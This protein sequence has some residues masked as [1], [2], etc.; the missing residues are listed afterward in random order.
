[1]TLRAATHLMFAGDASAA[2]DL[3]AAVF[4][5]FRVQQMERYGP[6]EPGAEG[7]VKRAD[8]AFAGHALIVIDSPVRHDFTF[9]PAISLFVDCE[10]QEMLDTAFAALSNGGRVFMPIDNYGFSRSFGWCADRFGVSWQL[11]LA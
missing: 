2:L 5:A 9:T 3:Y 7:W 10:N 11:N 8:A 6:G 4:P 1:M